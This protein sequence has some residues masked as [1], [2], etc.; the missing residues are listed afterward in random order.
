MDTGK[1]IFKSPLLLFEFVV[2]KSYTFFS[3]KSGKTT[4]S[5]TNKFCTNRLLISQKVLTI[6]TETILNLFYTWTFFLILPKHIYLAVG[7]TYIVITTGNPVQRQHRT[8]K[9]SQFGALFIF[10]GSVQWALLT[11]EFNHTQLGYSQ[12]TISYI[13]ITLITNINETV[14]RFGINLQWF[15]CFTRKMIVIL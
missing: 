5:N 14:L 13:L 6:F 9:S 4:S 7:L 15:N 1:S 2:H 8:S 11:N 3:T 12:Q 10:T